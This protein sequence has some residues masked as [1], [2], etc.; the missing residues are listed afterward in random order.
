[1]RTF[2]ERLRAIII[3][4]PY[5]PVSAEK[6]LE[7]INE[8]LSAAGAKML[9]KKHST[10]WG[11]SG[12][13]AFDSDQLWRA[14]H[15]YV[16]TLPF[17]A[18]LFESMAAYGFLPALNIGDLALPD[19]S[20]EECLITGIA[21]DNFNGFSYE[22]PSGTYSES[23]LRHAGTSSAFEIPQQ[24]KQ[25][26][27]T[28]TDLIIDELSG[29]RLRRLIDQKFKDFKWPFGTRLYNSGRDTWFSGYGYGHIIV[30]I[31]SSLHEHDPDAVRGEIRVHLH[32]TANGMT[33]I[34]LHLEYG[35][36]TPHHCYELFERYRSELMQERFVLGDTVGQALERSAIALRRVLD[37]LETER[38]NLRAAIQGKLDERANRSA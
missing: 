12:T 29:L 30:P 16:M 9:R 20:E 38:L 11:I 32:Q 1:M 27:G 22:T 6:K 7:L 13:S 25:K 19:D 2:K 5:A 37:L 21:G 33:R 15:E 28:G 23:R 26:V 4:C 24:I 18:A 3:K 17:N 35:T 14:L 8:M 36:A 31:Q 10:R 34:Q